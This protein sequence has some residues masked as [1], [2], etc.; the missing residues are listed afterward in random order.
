MVLSTHRALAHTA[1][2]VGTQTSWYGLRIHPTSWLKTKITARKPVFA[3]RWK[4]GILYA[5]PFSRPLL[6]CPGPFASLESLIC[7]TVVIVTYDSS[8]FMLL[9]YF[10]YSWQTVRLW[11]DGSG[12]WLGYRHQGPR[13]ALY[14]CQY[15]SYKSTNSHAVMWHVRTHTGVRPYGCSNCGRTFVAKHALHQHMCTSLTSMSRMP[16]F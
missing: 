5:F 3:P 16:N 10:L 14:F 9:L 2:Q 8:A 1:L 11:R 15:C 13:I 12:V 7:E 4:E 6:V